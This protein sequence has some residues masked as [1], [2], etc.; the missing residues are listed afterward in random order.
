[1]ADQ[2]LQ[3]EHSLS[4]ARGSSR[5]CML[6]S[7]RRYTRHHLPRAAAPCSWFC[8][9]TREI[10]APTEPVYRC[11]VFFQPPLNANS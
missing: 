1:M 5:L 2:S 6:A 9:G 4:T 10:A 3:A 8:L 11:W 7:L